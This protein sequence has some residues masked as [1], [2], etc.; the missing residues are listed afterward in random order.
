MP[1][2][3]FC[4]SFLSLTNIQLN[5]L[6]NFSVKK[7]AT[8]KSNIAEVCK[9]IFQWMYLEKT[10]N[11][12]IW[13]PVIESFPRNWWGIVR[14]KTALLICFIYRDQGLLRPKSNRPGW[15]RCWPFNLSNSP[16]CCFYR[17]IMIRECK[18]A[19]RRSNSNWINVLNYDPQLP[20]LLQYS[21]TCYK[22]GSFW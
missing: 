18:L 6:N 10:K 19:P 7:Q 15:N 12:R 13:Q 21:L 3:C 5:Q 1:L 2:P 4:S 11:R 9:S 17:K 20:G 22:V 16:L 14:C 8:T